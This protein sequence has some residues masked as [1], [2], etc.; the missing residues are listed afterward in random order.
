MKEERKAHLVI[1]PGKSKSG[2]KP[3]SN[4]SHDDPAKWLENLIVIFSISFFS[5]KKWYYGKCCRGA[6]LV[7]HCKSVVQIHVLTKP[8][9]CLIATNKLL[10]I[11]QVPMDEPTIWITR[12][13]EGSKKKSLE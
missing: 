1:D 8:I 9:L 10:P 13:D 11:S 6:V 7:L 3:H 5:A 12:T 4:E 2:L